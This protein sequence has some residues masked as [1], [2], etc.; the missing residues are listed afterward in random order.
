VYRPSVSSA[1]DWKSDWCHDILSLNQ[2]SVVESTVSE[3]T[4]DVEW[5]GCDV[6]D[7]SLDRV[8]FRFITTGGDDCDDER[9]GPAEDESC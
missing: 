9:F 1:D 6:V 8:A 2:R 3:Q 5:E 4:S 7:Q